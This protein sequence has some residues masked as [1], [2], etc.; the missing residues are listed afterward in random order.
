MAVKDYYTDL[1]DRA[2]KTAAQAAVLSIGVETVQVDALSVDFTL[3]AGMAAGGALL[4]VLTTLGQR[5]IFGRE[6]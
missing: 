1:V 5:G 2:V 4:S 3:M 6:G